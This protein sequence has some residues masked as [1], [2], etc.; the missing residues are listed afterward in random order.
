MK[1]P[2]LSDLPTPP[3]GKAGWPWTEESPALSAKMDDGSPWPKIGIVTPSLNQG[4][5]IEETIRSVLLQGYPNL[6]YII[7]DGGSKDDTIHIIKKYEKW[8]SYWVSEADKGQAQ[9]INKGFR[10]TTGEIIAWINSD[11]LYVIDTLHEV[12]RLFI[13]F[14][15]IGI[16]HGD[17]VII[18]INN[19]PMEQNISQ[20]ILNPQKLESFF[21]NPIFQ[22][23]LFFKRILLDKTGFL[24]DQLHCTMDLDLWVRLFRATNSFYNAKTMSLFRIH[25][26]SKT[27]SNPLRFYLEKLMIISRY[28]GSF[29]LFKKY[30]EQFICQKSMLK[31][32]NCEE[33]FNCVLDELEKTVILNEYFD[34]ARK[35][36]ARIIANAYLLKCEYFYNLLDFKNSRKHL[37]IS[38]YFS[39]TILTDFKIWR[40]LFSMFL[41]KI[42][43]IF[44]RRITRRSHY[45]HLG[46]HWPVSKT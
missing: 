4:Q 10:K 36:K 5:F 26:N 38:L 9:A 28:K 22:P 2:S 23:S 31:Q 24:D 29:I 1:C 19:A 3:P 16:I 25:Q 43:I 46:W 35:N 37:K 45:K 8:L 11:D 7:I 15:N 21:P 12:A 32:T 17:G 40:L 27:S 42:F 6:E 30:L 41:P 14:N 13:L 39:K 33:T 44:L 34:C 20:Q 18:D